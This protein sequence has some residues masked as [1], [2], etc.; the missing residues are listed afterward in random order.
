MSVREFTLPDVGEGI[1]EAEVVRWLVEPGEEVVEDQPVA[2]V[3]TDKAVVEVPSPF[4]GIVEELRADEGDVVSVGSVIIT[5]RVDEDAVDE[6]A[7]ESPSGNGEPDAATGDAGSDAPSDARDAGGETAG[8]DRPIAPPS[9]RRLAREHGVDLDRIEPARPAGRITKADVLAA[10]ERDSDADAETPDRNGGAT[11]D[12]SEPVAAATSGPAASEPAAQAASGSGTQAAGG[13]TTQAASRSAAPAGRSLT[14]A[15]PNTRR[16]AREKGIDIDD[17]PTDERRDGEAYVT[18]EQVRRYARDEPASAAVDRE[19]E[20]TV[21][22]MAGA[23]AG[24]ASATSER[25]VE[26]RPYRGVRRTIGEQMV[27]SKFTAPHV[28]HHDTVTVA[29][30]VET[31]RRLSAEVEDHGT[32]LT[33]LPF[34]LKAVVTGLKRHP[35]LNSTLAEEDDEI[36][37]RN[38]YHI[39]IAVATDAGLMVPVVENVDEKG[40]AA[41]ADEVKDLAARARAR[42]LSPDEMSGGTFTTTNFGAI[43]G[44]YGTPIINHPETAILGLGAIDERAVV[45]DGDVVARPTLPLSL[46]FDHRVIDGADAAAFTNTVMSHLEQPE[47]LLLEA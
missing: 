37:L 38:E 18:E 42:E 43:G 39:G 11:A 24:E 27:R 16:I 30:L 6:A 8:H 46:S 17:V 2:E 10:V 22:R 45:E 40:V 34:I 19:G 3:E 36:R 44:E 12:A 41:L 25:G 7:T 26:T 23:A 13:A 4:T 47:L 9:V 28:T 1:A 15:R 20:Q 5:V 31:R 35:L 29:E 21:D 14:L 33:Y 32:S